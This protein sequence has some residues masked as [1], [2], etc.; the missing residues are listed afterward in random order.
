MP[1]LLA[2]LV[3]A[4]SLLYRNLQRFEPT[5]GGKLMADV[6]NQ[7]LFEPGK[8]GQTV[9]NDN[10]VRAPLHNPLCG[11][12]KKEQAGIKLQDC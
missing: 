12:C 10:A 1:P 3:K 2:K 8:W 7:Q 5:W 11:T 4:L 6:Q 9:R